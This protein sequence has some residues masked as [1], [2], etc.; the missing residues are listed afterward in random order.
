MQFTT[1]ITLL[2]SS[3]AVNAMPGG[4]GWGHTTSSCITKSTCSATTYPWTSVYTKPETYI[5]TCVTSY[6]STSTGSTPSTYTTTEATPY[7]GKSTATS[8]KTSVG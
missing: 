8:Y 1:L 2:A 6:P 5:S 4:G 3:V 7:V